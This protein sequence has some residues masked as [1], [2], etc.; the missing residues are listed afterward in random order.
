MTMTEMALEGLRKSILQGELKPGTQLV[1]AKLEKE[2]ALSREAI[3]DAIRQ[4]VGYGLAET[5]TNKGTYV[6][7]PLTL[8]ELE[9]IFELR[10]H[11]EPILAAAAL[12]N[13]TNDQIKELAHLSSQMEALSDARED[14]A[15]HF[16]L[17]REFHL[18][19]YKPAGWNHLNRA[20]ALWLDQIL[21]FRSC[22]CRREM[23]RD[24]SK[25]NKDHRGIL[26]A[27]RDKDADK[28]KAFV[29]SNLQS[30]IENI[31][32][33]YSAELQ[34]QI[35]SNVKAGSKELIN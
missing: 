12:K 29:R 32:R 23:Y 15:E 5:I 14:F 26:K 10:L 3:R 33:N 4:I 30:G 18:N 17:N 34:E 16:I 27:I 31:R 11:A 20:V 9:V 28:L 8:A 13:L 24:L 22:L 25:F 2:L 6:A 35:D 7:Q 19:L 21:I 1:P